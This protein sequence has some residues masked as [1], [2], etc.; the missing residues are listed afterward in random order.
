[1]VSPFFPSSV[2]LAIVPVSFN[3]FRMAP[4]RNIFQNFL[5]PIF[6]LEPTRKRID[7]YALESGS[8]LFSGISGKV[9]IPTYR[10][11]TL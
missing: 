11:H 4:A 5:H 8:N 3:A 2:K 10:K 6:N 1:M 7:Y 9:R